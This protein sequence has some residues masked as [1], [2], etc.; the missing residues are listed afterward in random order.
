MKTTSLLIVLMLTT[1][2]ASA[3]QDTLISSPSKKSYILLDLHGGY[4][5]P[6]GKYASSDTEDKLSG[7][8]SGGFFIQGGATWLGKN[9]LGLGLSYAFQRNAIQKI[10]QNDTLAGYYEPLG[11]RPWTNHYLLAGPVLFVQTGRLSILAKA[12]IGGVLAYSSN[13]TIWLPTDAADSLT[14]GPLKKSDGPG[15]GV[16]VQVL[17]GV[18]YRVTKNI[19]V[20][21]TL[22][23]LGGSPV[24]K[25]DYY[26]YYWDIDPE[27]GRLQPVYQG[28]EIEKKRRIST[29]N[30]GAGLTIK[31]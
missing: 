11:S 8:A 19:S 5:L 28:G 24:R 9:I 2:L 22:S 21:V 18:G 16:A 12:Q 23:Y 4:S 14:P 30:I 10:V 17:A 31:L 15:M 13:F 26:Y 7:Y 20:D 6:F 3:Q 25:R 1:T 29:F 27:T